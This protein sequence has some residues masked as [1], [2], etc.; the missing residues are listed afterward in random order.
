MSSYKDLVGTVLDKLVGLIS[1]E[2]VKATLFPIAV[3]LLVNAGLR[4]LHGWDDLSAFLNREDLLQTGTAGAILLAVFA[5]SWNALLPVLRDALR[6]RYWWPFKRQAVAALNSRRR[7]EEAGLNQR[8]ADKAFIQRQ[9]STWIRQLRDS[10]KAEVTTESKE[11]YSEKIP[12]SAQIADLTVAPEVDLAKDLQTCVG[13]LS[14]YLGS[15]NPQTVDGND[16]LDRDHMALVQAIQGAPERLAADAA[17]LATWIEFQ[18]PQGE[19]APTRFGNITRSVASYADT[20][21]GINF[22]FFWS[23]IREVLEESRAKSLAQAQAET[24]FFVSLVWLAVTTVVLWVVNL[25]LSQG[26]PWLF[27]LISTAGPLVVWF[28]YRM[29]VQ[30]NAL[31]ADLVKSALDFDRLK[32][33]KEFGFSDPEGNDQ[34]KALW[35]VIHHWLGYG[36]APPLK[37]AGE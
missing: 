11:R 13:S 17:R 6:G 33:L 19:L 27:L 37:Y 32:V 12:L 36:E 3:F 29:A 34:E 9:T 5:L 18:Y 31:Y 15:V 25:I 10:R 1:V 4:N 14:S 7:E 16:R 21:Y 28:L 24:D 23:R 20:R 22:D 26:S 30:T 8:I 2:F 35:Q